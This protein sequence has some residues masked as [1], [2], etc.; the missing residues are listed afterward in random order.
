MKLL[1]KNNIKKKEEQRTTMDRINKIKIF[2]KTHY[3]TLFSIYIVDANIFGLIPACMNLIVPFLKFIIQFPSVVYSGFMTYL[4]DVPIEIDMFT[5]MLG[6]M[7]QIMD[8]GLT[9]DIFTS[10]APTWMSIL[11]DP[12]DFFISTGL[13]IFFF[14]LAYNRKATE[15]IY[16]RIAIIC[17][18]FYLFI[19]SSPFITFVVTSLGVSFLS[20]LGISGGIWLKLFETMVAALPVVW[21]YVGVRN[22]ALRLT[23]KA[24]L[25]KAV[26]TRISW[27]G[28]IIGS[29]AYNP[30]VKLPEVNRQALKNPVCNT[31]F[32]ELLPIVFCLFASIGAYAIAII[33]FGADTTGIMDNIAR[34][35]DTM[36]ASFI[37]IALFGLLPLPNLGGYNIL[38]SIFP[39]VHETPSLIQY[40]QNKF[41]PNI[42]LVLAAIVF[43]LTPIHTMLIQIFWMVSSAGLTGFG[44]L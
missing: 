16:F 19:P 15:P 30:W 32:I 28:W 17:T 1:Q 5:T 44:L 24:P 40:R 3:M 33:N 23:F 43:S 35:C 21:L 27:L 18:I 22:L 7:D 41:V 29:H 20:T 6:E 34:L 42:V 38:V 12:I 31:L 8:N 39:K 14:V 25:E 2:F 11:M 4:Y 13:L 9:M 26:K 36:G 10:L 37:G